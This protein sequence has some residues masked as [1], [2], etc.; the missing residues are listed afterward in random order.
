MMLL[1]ECGH[2]LGALLTGGRVIKLIFP[3]LGFSQTIVHPNPKPLFVTWGGPIGGALM[4]LLILAI[5]RLSV[6]RVPDVLRFFAGFCLIANGAYIGV[7][8]I[9]R[10]GDA[11]DLI[12]LGTPRAVMI[13]FGVVCLTAGLYFWHRTRGIAGVA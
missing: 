9:M 4:P 8:W 7:G 6:R 12:Q 13:L 3:A 1:H 2:M 11:G 5:V 10:A